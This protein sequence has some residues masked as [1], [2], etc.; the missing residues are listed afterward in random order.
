[1]RDADGHVHAFIKQMHQPVDEQ[2][3]HLHTRLGLQEA[4][5]DGRHV[6]D[7][8]HLRCGDGQQPLGLGLCTA[9]CL[10]GLVQV[11][12]DGA[13]VLQK[14]L[15]RLGQPHQTCTALEQQHTQPRL[16]RRNGARDGRG[17]AAQS[18]ARHGKAAGIGHGHKTAQGV[19]VVHAN[20]YCG[21]RNYEKR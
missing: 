12:Q 20:N 10:L 13:A 15:A 16:Q 5:H 2:R 7:A 4:L 8:E 14:A 1:M 19:E 11:V 17:G 6:L 9:G 18:P 3:A 21:C